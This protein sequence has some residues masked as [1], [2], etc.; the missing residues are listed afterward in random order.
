MKNCMDDFERLDVDQSGV[1]EPLELVPII[2]SMVDAHPVTIDLEKCKRFVKIFDVY[3]DGVIRREEYSNF[4]QFI[5]IMSVLNEAGV[6]TTANAE[7]EMGTIQGRCKV[8]ALLE[9]LRDG[10]E[11][12]NLVM[13]HIPEE[14]R[15]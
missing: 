3:G 5:F 1:L 12:L 6:G 4:A 8:D 13:R 14:L 10:K 7:A 2:Q 11:K 9:W 15:I